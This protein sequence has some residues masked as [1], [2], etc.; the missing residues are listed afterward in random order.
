MLGIFDL[1]NVVTVA[2][3]L[4]KGN[5]PFSDPTIGRPRV[6]NKVLCTLVLY[7]L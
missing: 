4:S 5:S 6:S 3:I 2:H 1:T 7:K